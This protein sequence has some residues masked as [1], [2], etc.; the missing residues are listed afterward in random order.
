MSAKSFSAL[1]VSQTWNKRVNHV[2]FTV[3]SMYL[4][5][6]L[7]FIPSLWHRCAV[8]GKVRVFADIHVY[9]TLPKRVLFI[10]TQTS[11]WFCSISY[12][13][14]L[15]YILF[16]VSIRWS[17]FISTC[18]ILGQCV[19]T[20]TALKYVMVSCLYTGGA[21]ITFVGTSTFSKKKWSTY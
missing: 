21:Y 3:C 6:N 11:L 19:Q 14:L 13:F 5:H 15:K 20:F 9:L 10:C 2:F 17:I 1:S 7:P 18:G 16:Y 4:G 12:G 8:I